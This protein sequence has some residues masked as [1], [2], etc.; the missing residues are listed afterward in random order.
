MKPEETPVE[1]GL[2]RLEDI[3]RETPM[4]REEFLKRDADIRRE[5]EEQV[6][7]EIRREMEEQV[8]AEIRRE[9]DE[10]M[11]AEQEMEQQRAIQKKE[12]EEQQRLVELHAQIQK[13]ERIDERTKEVRHVYDKLI[14]SGHTILM[15]NNVGTGTMYPQTSGVWMDSG[16]GHMVGSKKLDTGDI[17]I[18]VTQ[19]GVFRHMRARSTS[20]PDSPF[21]EEICPLYTFS[22]PLNCDQSK[23]LLYLSGAL[24]GGYTHGNYITKLWEGQAS[25]EQQGHAYSEQRRQYSIDH[26]KFE[27]VIR[28]IPGLYSN[29][30]WKQLDGFFGAYF[31]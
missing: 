29:G 9:M 1:P 16:S 19:K 5:M 23:I 25:A 14:A 26:K 24:H 30:A 12:Q 18:L 15:W 4:T 13:V 3:Q 11:R 2:Y 8:R 10:K 20:Q 28:L 17:F 27:S 22:N 6:R 31:N 7:A 21:L